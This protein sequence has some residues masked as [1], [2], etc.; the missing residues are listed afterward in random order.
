MNTADATVDYPLCKWADCEATSVNGAQIVAGDESM[1]T[2][3]GSCSATVA[4]RL[5]IHMKSD[6]NRQ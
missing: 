2:L 6:T 3:P 5:P 1:G 4:I